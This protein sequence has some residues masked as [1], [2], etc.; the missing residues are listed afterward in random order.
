MSQP[1]IERVAAYEVIVPAKEGAI[2]SPEM[3]SFIGHDWDRMPICLFELTV[4]DGITALG[5]VGRGVT[6]ASLDG[7]L[8]QLPGLSLTGPSLRF[9]PAAWRGPALWGG[10]IIQAH[11]PAFW[12]SPSPMT[13]G[14]EMALL[15]WTGKRL[16]CRVVDL[17]GG[18]YREEI[19]VDYWC[20]RK[21][22]S[23][24]SRTVARACELGFNGLKMK[25]RLGD[26]V[27][28]QM[29]A[30]REAGGED[31]S[32]TID[33]MY[34]WLG[35]QDALPVLKGLEAFGCGV[36]VEDPFPA[37]MPEFWHRAR[38]VSSVP[39]ICHAHGLDQLRRFLQERC[40]DAYNCAG[41]AVEFLTYARTLEVAGYSCWHG[42]SLEL[43]IGQAAGMHATAAARACT[44][45]SDFQ[46]GLIREHTLITWGWPYRDGLLP[47]PPGPGLGVELDREALAR[48]TVTKKEYR[49][50]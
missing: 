31:F 22:P 45:P 2:N 10:A 50:A 4:S 41:S 15:D 1:I 48:Y 28:E 34:Q 39:L 20:G 19:Q 12:A 27:I 26:P 35:P 17:L 7:W 23:D 21:T 46:S 36:R 6:L 25:S 14:V 49:Q 43:G 38:Q 33:P 9:L 32:V 13:A 16:G 11:P 30:I 5:E 47:L 29:K 44:M 18:A 42:S 37:E 8:A 40:A 3:G 24:L